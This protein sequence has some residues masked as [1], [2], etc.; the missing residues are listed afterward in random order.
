MLAGVRALGGGAESTE[1]K[2]WAVAG[3]AAQ[4]GAPCSAPSMVATVPRLESN[5]YL[6]LN[7]SS[8]IY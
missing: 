1:V 7:I 5:Q 8:A 4:S 6:G 2:A 3:D